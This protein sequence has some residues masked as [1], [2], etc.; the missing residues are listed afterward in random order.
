MTAYRRLPLTGLINAREL[1]GYNIPDGT[2]KYGVFIRSEVPSKLTDSDL[3]FLKNYGVTTAVDFRG[4][5]EIEKAPDMLA[6]MDWVSYHHLPLFDEDAAQGAVKKQRYPGD[7]ADF[8]WRDHY[9][10]MAETHK[11]WVLQ[12]LQTLADAPGAALFHCTTG[13]DRTG[14][15]SAAIL[16]ICGVSREDIIA[17]YSVSEIYLRPLYLNMTHL[18]PPG[19]KADL[20]NPFFSTAPDNMRSLL[21]H[22]DEKYG[23]M[24]GYLTDCGVSEQLMDRIRQKLCL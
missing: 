6:G 8:N 19:F 17:D 18:M 2:T 16:S 1:G 20:S 7:T 15:I 4:G 5:E 23:G 21:E 24:S 11:D 22:M 12:V 14:L 13:K 9:I 3:E 10:A